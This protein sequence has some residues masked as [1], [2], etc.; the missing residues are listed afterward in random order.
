MK[1]VSF[2]LLNWFLRRFCTQKWNADDMQK[3]S[4]VIAIVHKYNYNSSLFTINSLVFCSVCD[5]VHRESND[6][7]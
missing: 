1:C 2:P 4:S 3:I 5:I 7:N 6:A